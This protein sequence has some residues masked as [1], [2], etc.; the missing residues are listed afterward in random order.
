MVNIGAMDGR[1][2][3]RAGHETWAA[4][5]AEALSGGVTTPAYVGFIGEEG[6]R[7]LPTGSRASVSG[8]PR[9]CLR[10]RD[11]DG[12]ARR[13]T[14]RRPTAHRGRR[15]RCRRGARGRGGIARARST[16]AADQLSTAHQPE[17]DD[18]Q[19][20]WS[21]WTFTDTPFMTRDKVSAP[22]RHYLGSAPAS[23]YA[24][25]A[26]AND[27]EGLPPAYIATAEFDPNR[28]EAIVY[29]SRAPCGTLTSQLSGECDARQHLYVVPIRETHRAAEA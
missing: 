10:G 9:R 7:R 19:E 26:R 17:L 18:R 15:S 6:V 1:V 8:R 25:P 24:G 27:L 22:W 3:E 16:A 4:G 13:R 28:H 5:L 29:A 2:A 14:R 11:V 21:A 20:T 23:P 12:G